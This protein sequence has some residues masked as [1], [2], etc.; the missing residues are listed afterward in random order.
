MLR[1]PGSDPG[2]SHT[3]LGERMPV[4]TSAGAS[5]R[6]AASGTPAG[7]AHAAVGASARGGIACSAAPGRG[8][9]ARPHGIADSPCVARTLCVY[10]PY[11]AAAGRPSRGTYASDSTEI[12]SAGCRSC[13]GWAIVRRRSRL[14]GP[15][16]RLAQERSSLAKAPHASRTV[17][18][19]AG[20]SSLANEVRDV[21]PTLIRQRGSLA[22]A[23]LLRKSLSLLALCV[24]KRET[25]RQALN[26]VR[27]CAGIL[28]EGGLGGAR[29]REHKHC[30]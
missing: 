26:L 11:A 1:Q 9:G 13:T 3:G 18:L 5:A 15:E 16:T 10:A 14:A 28:C 27:A 12:G 19:L 24:Q 22:S 25:L 23:R 4:V 7:T 29:Q 6:A 2:S 8:G 21:L 20:R 30:R 17:T